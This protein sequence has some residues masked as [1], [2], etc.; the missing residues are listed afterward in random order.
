[1]GAS[2]CS[3]VTDIRHPNIKTIFV[4]VITYPFV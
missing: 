4:I 1:L 3:S 2:L